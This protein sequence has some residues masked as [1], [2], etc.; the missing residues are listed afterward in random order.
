M[1]NIGTQLIARHNIRTIVAKRDAI[2]DAYSRAF[3]AIVEAKELAETIPV[4]CSPA[5]S[6]RTVAQSV[7]DIKDAATLETGVDVVTR[8]LDG[9]I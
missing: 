7:Y 1:N 5:P 6:L 4:V 3:Q 2:I 8:H 9:N